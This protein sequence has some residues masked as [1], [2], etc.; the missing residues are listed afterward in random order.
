MVWVVF[1]V[2]RAKHLKAC[3]TC[4]SRV[5]APAHFLG[6]RKGMLTALAIEGLKLLAT[7]LGT[8]QAEA[9][10]LP[11]RERL[12]ADSI[13]F[14]VFA[15]C[16]PAHYHAMF[17]TPSPA[18]GDQTLDRIRIAALGCL[19][20]LVVDVHD[21]GEIGGDVETAFLQIC[22]MSHGIASL[23]VDGLLHRTDGLV[24][25]PETDALV[26]RIVRAQ[27]GQLG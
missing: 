6:S 20:D 16:H 27:V 2:S 15:R 13:E 1:P 18:D 26:E 3:A 5:T 4:M 25:G 8:A 24:E 12:V 7:E 17:R 9:V 23:A 19:R 10:H 21:A 22:A 14:V 11:G